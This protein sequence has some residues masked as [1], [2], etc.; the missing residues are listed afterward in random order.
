[1][2]NEISFA[3][4]YGNA[5]DALSQ[6]VVILREPAQVIY[7]N[8]TA[9]TISD[10]KDGLSLDDG[11]LKCLDKN[12]NAVLRQMI[13]KAFASAC[14][15]QALSV[16]RL[17]GVRSYSL[18]IRSFEAANTSP[19][20]SWPAVMVSI[21]SFTALDYVEQETLSELFRLSP[22]EAALTLAL[23]RAGSLRDAARTCGVTEGSARQYL[24]RVFQKRGTRGQ[25]ELVSLIVG[26]IPA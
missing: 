17:S 3:D 12:V 1:M 6:G 5:L 2:A 21:G 10:K 20:H 9:H 18:L 11:E 7:A 24:K 23:I 16:P 19:P 26:S 13:A 4:L 22:S 25:V 14:P 15:Q 8:R